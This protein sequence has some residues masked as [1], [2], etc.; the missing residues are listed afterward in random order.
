M[1]KV[2]PKELKN[3]YQIKRQEIE[4]AWKKTDTVKK[5]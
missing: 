4:K 5:N 1:I 2:T 3:E